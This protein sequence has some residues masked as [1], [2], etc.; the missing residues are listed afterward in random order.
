MTDF[1]VGARGRLGSTIARLLDDPILL[2]PDEYR[3]WYMPGKESKISKYF[4]SFVHE[5]SRIFI[6]SGVLDPKAKP[7]Q[8]W[9]VNYDLPKNIIAALAPLGAKV[10]TFGT[11]L[12]E[13]SGVTNE[14]V[15]SKRALGALVS[16]SSELANAPL[17]FQIHTLYGNGAPSPFM[18][19]GQVLK[20]LVDGTTFKMTSGIQLREYHHVVDDSLAVLRLS[21]DASGVLPLSHGGAVSLRE[22]AEAIFSAT[23]RSHLLKIGSLPQPSAEVY[24]HVNARSFE[25]ADLTFRDTIEGVCSYMMDCLEQH[26]MKL[27]VNG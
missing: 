14:Y 11:V 25:L 20:A 3:N 10:V 1:V 5:G 13:I 21:R 4:D 17:H 12:E 16:S 19:L 26:S 7:S 22:L 15:A 23:E 9:Q 27:S 8:I 18:F 2:P 6:V 24:T